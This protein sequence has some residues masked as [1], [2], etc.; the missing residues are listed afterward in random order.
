ML[1]VILLVF[2]S[3]SL[4]VLGASFMF[5]R[6]PSRSVERLMMARAGVAALSAA[7]AGEEELN[8]LRDRSLSGI[9][10]MHRTLA[11]LRIGAWLSRL[12]TQA[13]VKMKTGTLVLSIGVFAL[14]GYLL[15]T[16]FRFGIPLAVLVGV[17]TGTI[18]VLIVLRIRSR[19]LRRF[20]AQF[21]DAI[22][23]LSRAIRAGHAFNTGVKMIA[24]EMP[25]PVG[26]E[27]QRV[28]EEQNY[29]LPMKSA[30]LNLLERVELL[31]L[32]LFVVA[33]LIQRQSGGNLAELLSKIAQTIRERFRI[34]RQL[35][36]HTAQAKM[37]G[38]ILMC[39]PPVMGGVTLALNYE[40][41]KIIFQDPWGIR[42]LIGAAVLQLVG[43]VWIRKI[44]N[45]EV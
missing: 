42:M 19:R 20:E 15:A 4:L 22:D 17:L 3:T 28:F 13:D 8:I 11:K 32:R 27:F 41:M 26:K 45:I 40:Y 14:V 2:F 37:T 39:L 30:L 43:L 12:L 10:P 6:R 44:V 7:G 35:K 36:V 25:E 21:P 9:A 5:V 38:I 1:A 23:L 18:P 33:V 16:L 24:D 31:D 29:G 34:F